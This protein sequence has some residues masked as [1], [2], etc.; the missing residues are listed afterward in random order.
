MTMSFV[1]ISTAF[2]IAKTT[3][4]LT[5]VFFRSYLEK[6]SGMNR[7]EIAIVKV[8]ELTYSPEIAMDA[9]KYSDIVDIIPIIL[10]GVLI[11]KVDSIKIYRSVFG[12][13]F[14]VFP[15]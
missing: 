10:N 5:N 11:P 3:R 13:L 12:L 2:D 8:N 14:M 1:K 9:L 4:M 7:P 6:K 15:F